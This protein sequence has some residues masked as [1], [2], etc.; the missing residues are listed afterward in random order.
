[1]WTGRGNAP[2]WLA[3]LEVEGKKRENYLIKK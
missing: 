1:M 2:R 3:A